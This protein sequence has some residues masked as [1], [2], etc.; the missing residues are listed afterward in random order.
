M[1][2]AKKEG[3]EQGQ[4]PLPGVVSVGEAS[5]PQPT[6]TPPCL[7]YQQKATRGQR[8]GLVHDAHP[9]PAVPHTLWSYSL[10]SFSGQSIKQRPPSPF[11]DDGASPEP[12]GDLLE[13][14]ESGDASTRQQMWPLPRPRPPPPPRECSLRGCSSG[15]H[16]YLRGVTFYNPACLSRQS[17]PDSVLS[18]RTSGASLLLLTHF[19]SSFGGSGGPWGSS[20]EAAVTSD[21]VVASHLTSFR[22]WT[23]ANLGDSLLV[24]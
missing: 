19:Q 22:R 6:C 15:G 13:T 2:T 16:P 24:W 5:R 7:L 14:T 12:L 1:S 4:E 3:T 9:V 21:P 11:T 8:E 10:V 23:K 18:S 17:S 20:R